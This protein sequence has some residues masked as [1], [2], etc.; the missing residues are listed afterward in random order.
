MW[1][2]FIL[3]WFDVI[4]LHLPE[5]TEENH[6]NVRIFYALVKNQMKYVQNKSRCC[7]EG[8]S[9]FHYATLKAHNAEK[10]YLVYHKDT[11]CKTSYFM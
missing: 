1:K 3:A 4:A 6:E 5:I 7:K 11:F 10:L 2:A 9:M 8:T